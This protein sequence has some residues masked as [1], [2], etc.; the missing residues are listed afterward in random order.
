MT[1]S[2]LQTGRGGRQ[3]P[4]LA[5]IVGLFLAAVVLGA[6]AMFLTPQGRASAGPDGGAPAVGQGPASLPP[7]AIIPALAVG[8]CSLIQSDFMAG[9]HGNFEAVVLEGRN[10]VHYYHVNDDVGKPWSRAQIIT[11]RATGPGCLIQSDFMAGGH[12]NFEVV[13]PEGNEL[14]HYFHINADVLSPWQR[15]QVITA[16]ASGPGCIIQSDFGAG[17]HGNFEVVVREGANLVHYFHINDNVNNPWQ[18][19]Q[20]ISTQATGPGCILQSDFMAGGHGNFEVVVQEGANLVHYFHINDNVGNPWLRG[21]VISTQATGPAS[22]IQSDFK[23]GVNGNLELV[24]PEGKLLVH[25]FFTNFGAGWAWQRGQTV[26]DR[27]D[28]WAAFIQGDF[29]AGGHG[30]FEVITGVAD[31][32]G[33]QTAAPCIRHHFHVNDDVGAPWQP[34]QVV[35]YTGRSQKVC[36]LT[37]ATDREWDY[38]TVNRTTEF[39]LWGTDL[40]QP[41]AHKGRVFYFFGDTV[42]TRPPDQDNWNHDS[43]ASSTDLTPENCLRL[44]FL[45]GEEGRFRPLTIPGVSLEAFETPTGGFSANGNLY[46]FVASG[47]NGR[48]HA[49]SVLARSLDDGLTFAA[50]GDVSNDKFINIS[51]T[52]VDSSAWPGLPQAGAGVLLWASGRYRADDVYLAYLP[53]AAADGNPRPSLRYL[54]GVEPLS[55]RPIWSSSEAAARPLFHQPC[56]GELSVVWNPYVERW[57][58]LYNCDNPRGINLRAARQPWGPWSEPGVIFEP[59]ADGGYCHF[60]HDGAGQCDRASDPGREGEY[61]G[62]YGPYV[63]SPLMTGAGAETTI[64]YTLSTWNPYEVMLMRATLQVDDGPPVSPHLH[65][66]PFLFR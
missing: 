4:G 56:V 8:P 61:G 35:A 48:D 40:G 59:R 9:G 26:T 47:W 25:Y 22:L 55:G 30:N 28:G 60:I 50:M 16:Q 24:A 32:N 36:Q 52:V 5:I 3:R 43:Y 37:G 39:G 38:P 34:G 10:L 58:M 18:R 63:I 54:A 41:V 27:A 13:V 49:R 31:A 23:A 1:T 29:V 33:C 2:F 64:Y 14:V 53:L 42:T 21:P 19:G 57:L 62:E 15:G 12:G 66:L 17:G 46:L 51:P 7:T 20:T 44:D 11:T 65:F 6:L 45:T